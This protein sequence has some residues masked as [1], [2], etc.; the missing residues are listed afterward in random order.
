MDRI[1]EASNRLLAARQQRSEVIQR[2]CATQEFYDDLKEEA[3]QMGMSAPT[4]NAGPRVDLVEGDPPRVEM[5]FADGAVTV[6]TPVAGEMRYVKFAPHR[7]N[8]PS[9][10]GDL[11][12]MIKNGD[13]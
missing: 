9:L 2:I 11:E 8:A 6:G 10:K 3:K 12:R 7:F 4:L 5:H 1:N 13:Q